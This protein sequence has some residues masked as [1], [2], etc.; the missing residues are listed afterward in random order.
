M[1]MVLI[2]TDEY[3]IRPSPKLWL[4]QCVHVMSNKASA[5]III[6]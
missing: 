3:C 6:R 2:C 5:N 4:G 1:M